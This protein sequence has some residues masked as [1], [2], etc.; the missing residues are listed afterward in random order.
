MPTF[1]TLLR[2]KYIYA[3]KSQPQNDKENSHDA[4]YIDTMDTSLRTA[5]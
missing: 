2:N 1:V 4:R 5:V 3:V